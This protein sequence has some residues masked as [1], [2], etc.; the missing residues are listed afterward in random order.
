MRENRRAVMSKRMIKTTLVEMLQG[1]PLSRIT[2]TSLCHTADINRSTFYAHYVDIYNVMEDAEEDF[3]QKISFSRMGSEAQITLSSIRNLVSYVDKH[4]ELYLVLLENGY[5]RKKGGEEWSEVL[6]DK[7]MERESYIKQTIKT[8]Y[9]FHGTIE[10]LKNWVLGKFDI[11][12]QEMS[13][14]LYHLIQKTKS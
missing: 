14:L 4:R 7:T 13:V 3:I 11:P 1:E 2:V 10:I 12:Y 8:M 6:I 5:L 9:A